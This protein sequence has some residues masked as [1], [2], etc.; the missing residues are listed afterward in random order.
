MK[1]TEGGSGL[2]GRQPEP[3]YLAIGRVARP[4]GVR[5]ELRVEVLT[6][7]PEWVEQRAYLYVGPTHQRYALE[8][9]RL[10]Q[11]VLL[12]KLEGCDDRDAAEALRGALIEVPVE[13]AIPLD[14]GEYYHFQLVGL[15]VV[16]ETNEILGEVVEVMTLPKNANEVYVVHGPLGEILLPAIE[17]V[18][19]S[20]DVDAG[21]IVVRPLPGLLD[22]D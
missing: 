14:E 11:D 4:H 1:Q 2:P 6:D 8:R 12:L 20:L 7:Y 21:Q 22:Y 15:Q 10:H 13:D 16:T 17:D 5:G 3:R 19:V 18:V 9:V